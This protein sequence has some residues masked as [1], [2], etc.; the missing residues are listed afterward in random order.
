VAAASARVEPR[1]P[2]VAGPAKSP[3]SGVAVTPPHGEPAKQPAWESCSVALSVDD[4]ADLHFYVVPDG[5]G[6]PVARSPV[7]R[8]RQADAVMESAAGRAALQT[9]VTHLL[10]AGWQLVGRDDDPWAL[11]FRRR[12]RAV[13]PVEHH[14]AGR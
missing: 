13:R 9:L 8:A 1:E 5:A 3:E 12:V 2:A 6:D 10:E 11:R 14:P 4:G 7:F